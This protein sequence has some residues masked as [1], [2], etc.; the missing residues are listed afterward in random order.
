MEMT[1]RG[2]ER[3]GVALSGQ[4]LLQQTRAGLSLH[5]HTH[6]IPEMLSRGLLPLGRREKIRSKAL[7]FYSTNGTSVIC[8]N[9]WQW[10]NNL[11]PEILGLPET[12]HCTSRC[13]WWQSRLG[14][15]R[16][17]SVRRS[18]DVPTEKQEW[19]VSGSLHSPPSRSQVLLLCQNGKFS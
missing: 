1:S 14:V 5:G 15:Q 4:G 2:A 16:G 18:H 3:P 19:Q 17:T 12:Q 9:L 7:Q 6:T 10:F 13:A 11:S 8:I